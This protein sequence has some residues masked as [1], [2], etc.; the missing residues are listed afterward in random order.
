MA[1]T[2]NCRPSTI[3]CIEDEYSAFCLDQAVY[4]FGSTLNS[5]LEAVEGKTAKDVERQR[6]RILDEVLFPGE[7]PKGRFL[8]PAAKFA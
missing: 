6:Q 2:Y 3:L 4:H 5:R 7:T 8:D 1:T